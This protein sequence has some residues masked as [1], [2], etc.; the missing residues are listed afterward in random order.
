MLT[1]KV[2]MLNVYYY[3][4]TTFSRMTPIFDETQDRFC[5]AF[6]DA[7]NIVRKVVT[8][9]NVK[10]IAPMIEKYVEET[11]TNVIIFSQ[12]YYNST[13]N[14][15]ISEKNRKLEAIVLVRGEL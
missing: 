11:Y 6:M 2:S 13:Y 3:N 14:Q 4:G 15:I 8:K 10:Q 9:M 5:V 12:K 7:E 1:S